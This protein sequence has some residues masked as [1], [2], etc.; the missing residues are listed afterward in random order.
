MS[1]RAT[2]AA[3]LAALTLSGIAPSG[4]MVLCISADGCADLEP[5]AP[6]SSRCVASACDDAHRDGGAPRACHDVPVL[7]HTLPSASAAAAALVP[8]LAVLPAALAPPGA[9]RL[10]PPRAGDPPPPRA[11]DPRLVVLQL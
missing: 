7:Q 5:A 4:A 3:A 1:P 9:R 10:P 6:W 8:A 2:L 11:Y